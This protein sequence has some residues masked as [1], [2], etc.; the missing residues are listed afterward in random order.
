MSFS[1]KTPL[2][3]STASTRKHGAGNLGF[4]LI[5]LLVVI[6][7]IA[8]LI[9][10]LLPA[11]QQA[12][13]AARRS[14]CKNNLKQIGLAL[15]NYHDVHGT[16]P[17]GDITL[18]RIQWMTMILPMVDQAALYQKLDTAGAFIGRNT[19]TAPNWHSIA[20]IATTGS[21]PLAKTPIP[22]FMCPTDPTDSMNARLASTDTTWPGTYAK[23][24]YAGIYT[25]VIYNSSGTKSED[26]LATFFNNSN[27]SFRK[28]IDGT[29]NTLLVGERAA[30]SPYHGSLWIGWHNLP[31]TLGDSHEF[32]SRIRC[33]RVSNDTDYPINGNIGFAA[34]S[35]HTGG[36][37]FLMGD[38]AVRFI[39][40]NI[41]LVTYAGLGS[42][43]GGEV[44]GDF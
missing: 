21:P 44:V 15:H 39:S 38:G 41:S 4:T 28:I 43:N 14:Q 2:S 7:I 8:I 19:A 17:P 32:T 1:S 26:R 12:R 40:E 10:L 9:A 25:S 18:S 31:G 20:A 42:I 35:L 13:E 6:A 37:H 5:E 3:K 30:K 23:S 24:N 33:N 27:T 11:V 34:S 36:A 29:S 22:A 16:F